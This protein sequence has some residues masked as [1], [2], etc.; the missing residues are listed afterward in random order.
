MGAKVGLRRWVLLAFVGS[1]AA[2]APSARGE[3]PVASKLDTSEARDYVG[4]WTLTIDMQGR[5]INLGL[6]VVDLSGKVGATI[7]SEQ[8]PEPTA[9][10]DISID[11]RGHMLLKYPMKFGQQEFKITV[12]AEVAAAGLEGKFVEDSGLFNAPFTA[13]VANADPENRETRSRNRRGAANS[14]RVR[15][16][17]DKVNV[18]FHPLAISSEDYKRLQNTAVGEVFKFVGGRATKLMTDVNMK[19]AQAVV[20]KENVA[21]NYPGV[22]SLWMRKSADGWDLV[23][24]NEADIWGT[25][26]NAAAD[27]AAVTLEMGAA[28]TA[29]DAFKVEIEETANGG[30]LRFIWGDKQWSAPFEVEGFVRKADAP[31]APAATPAAPVPAAASGEKKGD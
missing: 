4:N 1:L 26:H 11:E 17:D 19:F 15:F 28:A 5:K 10:E 29:S 18:N 20:K 30:V 25:M 21:P 7:D 2:L 24:N 6:K 23:F 31:A 27:A 3:G 16:G 22:Y 8:M 13:A 14:V 12:N 9:I